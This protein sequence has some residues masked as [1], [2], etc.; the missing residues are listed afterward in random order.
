MPLMVS[1]GPRNM[2]PIVTLIPGTTSGTND[3]VDSHM[4]GAMEYEG[5]T[6]VDG[7]T[8]QYAG[9]GNGLFNLAIDFPMSP[10]MI[11]EI[12]VLTSNY[13][14]QYG[15][16]AGVAI[17]METK[18]GTDAFHGAAYEY[19]RNT[20]L[21]AREFDAPKRTPDLENNFGI[22]V[23]GPIPIPGLR[24]AHSKPFF[25]VDWER[26]RQIGG[27]FAPT[28][29]IPS[30]QE[31]MGDFSDWKTASGALIPIYDPATTT[32][33]N[34]VAQRQQFMGC[35]GTTPNVICP[36]DP[37]LANSLA[38]KWLNYFPTPTSPGPVNNWLSPTAALDY[39]TKRN[40]ATLRFD[41]YLGDKDHIAVSYYK[42][43]YPPVYYSQLPLPISNDYYCLLC[44]NALSR[45]NW[46]HTFTPSL[47]NHVGVGYILARLWG[48][49]IDAPY[50]NVLPHIPGAPGYPYPPVM[51]FTEG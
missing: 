46:D 12:N 29:T 2:G 13:E 34:G 33:V 42:L 44:R 10:D 20:V 45:L 15:N 8:V 5:E 19:M 37:R 49:N 51:Q 21:D 40:M 36:T 35:N 24:S 47:L 1:G 26:Y 11:N 4:N 41:E 14:P 48:A 9:G 16:A 17:V 3:A 39:Y 18:S 22:A 27:T 32:F 38:T 43:Y 50:A 7:V 31:R 28:L 25:F 30:M 6:I 23:G